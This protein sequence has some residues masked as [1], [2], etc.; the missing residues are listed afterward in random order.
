MLTEFCVF[1]KQTST[2]FDGYTLVVVGFSSK[3]PILS[4]CPLMYLYLFDIKGLFAN[5][6][7]LDS[8]VVNKLYMKGFVKSARAYS[9]TLTTKKGALSSCEVFLIIL[10]VLMKKFPVLQIY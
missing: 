2:T 5:A 6:F 8:T 9:L 3:Q 10:N 4:L 7:E 1:T